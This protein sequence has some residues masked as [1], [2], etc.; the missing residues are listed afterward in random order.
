MNKKTVPATLAEFQAKNS[1]LL[2]VSQFTQFVSVML[3]I[4]NFRLYFTPGE[5][6]NGPVWW[7]AALAVSV[8]FAV[9]ELVYV[10]T[11]AVT[12]S[13]IKRDIKR[14]STGGTD[15]A[16]RWVELGGAGPAVGRLKEDLRRLL[17]GEDD[18]KDSSAR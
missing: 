14:L 8:Y 5:E 11:F 16:T 15:P 17:D 9:R 18:L 1:Y 3:V 10:W 7:A 12:K 13:M 2:R 6:G 4:M